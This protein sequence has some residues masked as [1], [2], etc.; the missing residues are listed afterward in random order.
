MITQEQQDATFLR[1]LIYR[2]FQ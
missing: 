2:G 1:Y